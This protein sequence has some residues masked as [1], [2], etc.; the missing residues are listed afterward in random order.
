MK[1]HEIKV[2]QRDFKGAEVKKEQAAQNISPC[3]Q[4]P[5]GTGEFSIDGEQDPQNNE[6]HR[7]NEFRLVRDRKDDHDAGHRGGNGPDKG[8]SLLD[9]GMGGKIRSSKTL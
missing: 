8:K 2:Q 9:E 6:D 7:I 4:A 1:S 5:L 3:D